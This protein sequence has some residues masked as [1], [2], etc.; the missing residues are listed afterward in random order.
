MSN[1]R[2]P[3]SL[4]RPRLTDQERRQ[5]VAMVREVRRNARADA[6]SG[7]PAR[8][9]PARRALAFADRLAYRVFWGLR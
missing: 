6:R 4:E 1:R 2:R 5:G 7:N 3:K 8:R 9:I